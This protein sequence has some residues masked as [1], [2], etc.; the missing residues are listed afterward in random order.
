M[1]T[2][3]AILSFEGEVLGVPL[4]LELYVKGGP[5]SL[6]LTL[7]Q[8]ISI[9][10]IWDTISQ[11]LYNVSGLSL[12]DLT[13]GPWGKF[14]TISNPPPTI[15]PSLWITPT[16]PDGSYSAYLELVFSSSICIGGEWEEG[17]LKIT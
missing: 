4:D 7:Q 16:G 5:L 15:Q 13:G 2:P 6:R 8:P 3:E 17:P 11:A 9:Q 1:G 10:K 14:L 12:P